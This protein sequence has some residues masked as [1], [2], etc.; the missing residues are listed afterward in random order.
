MCFISWGSHIKC[1]IMTKP[2]SQSHPEVTHLNWLVHRITTESLTRQLR[3]YA[4]GVLVDV[5]CGIKPYAQLTKGIVERHIGVDH[6]ETKHELSNIDVIASCYDT[7]LSDG[8]ADTVLCTFVLEH[9]E[10]PHDAL[11]EI[12][13]I[14]KPEGYLILGAPLFWHLHEEPRDFYRYTKYG[15]AH[16]LAEAGFEVVEIQPLSGFI[17]TFSQELCFYLEGFTGRLVRY[18]LNAVQ[19]LLQWVAYRLHHLGKDRATRFTWAYLAVAK[20][21]SNSKGPEDTKT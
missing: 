13:R 14:L 18:P 6:S 9:L 21:V 5:G 7:T 2:I 19:F 3:R 20:K 15:L 11:R 1:L 4:S 16:L 12:H 10:R 17:V 8:S